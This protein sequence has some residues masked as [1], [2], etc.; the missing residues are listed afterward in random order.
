M[1]NNNHNSSKEEIAKLR[2]WHVEDSGNSTK[3]DE[4]IKAKSPAKNS[5]K[6]APMPPPSNT[7]RS[8]KLKKKR[9]M[10]EK[11]EEEITLI[12]S[13]IIEEADFVLDK[14][15]YHQSP[16]MRQT[17]NGSRMVGGAKPTNLEKYNKFESTSYITPDTPKEEASLMRMTKQLWQQR[18]AFLWVLYGTIGISVSL[19]ISAI[20]YLCGIIE[21]ARVKATG[22][23]LKDGDVAQAYLIWVGSSLGMAV[24][25]ASL[26]VL[27]P[28][29][30]SSGIPGLI[31]YLNGV[32]PKGGKSPVTQKETSF[33]SL[34]TMAA[35]LIGMIASIPSGL[36]I[37]PEGP[38]IHISALFAMYTA[39]IVQY[40]ESKLFPSH[41]YHAS[42]SETRDF[43]A[44]G[45]ACGICT[46]FRAP[47]AGTLFVVEE[48]ASFF[49]TNHLEY[50]FFACLAAYWCQWTIGLNLT[51]TD[52][53]L[54]KFQQTTGYFC[55]LDS[56]TNML[57]YILM[58]ILGGVMGALF[59]QIVEHLNHLRAH[60]VHK[61]AV[62]RILEV[63]VIT[64]LTGTAVIFLPQFAPCTSSDRSIMMRDGSGC[65]SHEDMSQISHGTVSDKYLRSLFN[66]TAMEQCLTAKNLTT[67]EVFKKSNY[68]FSNLDKLHEEKGSVIAEVSKATDDYIIIDNIVEQ[69]KYIHLHYEHFY[70]CDPYSHT[71][72]DMAMLWLNGG[73]KGV[74]VL[75]QR[76]FPHMISKQTLIL[77]L[78]VYFLLAAITAGT[79][80]PAGLVVP[81]LLIGGSL[82]RLFGIFAL[83]T[84]KTMCASYEPWNPEI[85]TDLYYWEM[86]YRWIIRDC[87]M[88]DPGTYAV[89]GMAAFMGGSGRITVM[90]ATVLLELTADAG[91]I[92]PVGITCVISMLIGNS[93]NHGLYHGLIPIMNIP[94]LNSSPAPLMYVSRVRDIMHWG[95]VHIPARCHIGEL[96]MLHKRITRKN[97]PLSHNAFPVVEDPTGK[98]LLQGL[99]SRKDF[100]QLME[101][102]Q[103]PKKQ[104][105]LLIGKTRSEV[106]VMEY[107]D[108]SP[109]TVFPHT[110]VAR[111]YSIFR[112][113]GLRHLVVL[114]RDGRVCG[115][116]TRKDLMLYKLVEHHQRE[117]DLIKRLQQKVRAKQARNGFVPSDS[118]NGSTNKT[119]YV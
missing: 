37:G 109:I 17:Q 91:M 58:A 113:L 84:K 2:E 82:G 68:I 106:D 88:P 102:L 76:G 57:G 49:T 90:L 18:R 62:K 86:I 16:Y 97:K 25:A 59:N 11:I 104:K 53:T 40:A 51:G 3:D 101:D 71:Y 81:M 1:S 94:F 14:M 99:I 73:V 42:T 34:K 15:H 93:F 108:R 79:N 19:L 29:A 100:L 78:I 6:V 36:C 61:S 20:L 98:K 4:V 80:V 85:H 117:L 96:K 32:D 72:N 83:E 48:A 74:K 64:L 33:T 69:G 46:A 23:A 12:E 66:N 95:T 9:T 54:A 44:T 22:Y 5:S 56:P 45:A 50:T 112:K 114:E 43:L 103:H 13:E 7:K 39:K 65:L 28:A 116:I 30:A 41:S 87:Y 75:M 27:E 70:T 110:T 31:A 10:K 38:I 105:D 118:G 26:V 47:I 55:N 21:K 35:K 89:V 77:F 67:S 119:Q 92:A 60:H 115:M 52:A 111:A 24:F 8:S 63:V 107:A